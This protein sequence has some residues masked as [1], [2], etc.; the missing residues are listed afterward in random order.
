VNRRKGRLQFGLSYVWSKALGVGVGHPTDTRD[1]GY[2]PLTQD[3]T[4]SLAVNYIYDFPDVVRP[5]SRF[6]NPVTKIVLNGWQ[7]SGLTS[8]S[9]GA[10][11]N[12][13]YS[14]S[15]VSSAVLNRTITGSED[16]APR[17]VLTCNPNLSP[18]DRTID[19]WIKTSCFAPAPKGSVGL[20]S[21]YD[22]L[23]GPG[24]NQW[25]MNLFKNIRPNEKW[26]RIQ[27]RLEAY[28]AFNHPEWAS[29]N[30]NLVFNTAGQVIN[31]PTQLGGTGGRLG[32]GSLNSL[33]ANSQRILQIAAKVYF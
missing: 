17:V 12:V 7:L 3:R 25:D 24:I 5:G 16:V 21:G 33:R 32:F 22:R 1:Y 20:N 27:L 15:G 23:R 11:V 19:R 10:P 28:N 31:L 18:G 2:G 13:T 30:S 4:Q 29:F 26:P 14:V 8:L 6:M 9:S